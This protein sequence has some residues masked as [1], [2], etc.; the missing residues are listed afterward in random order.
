[1]NPTRCLIILLCS[2]LF[3]AAQISYGQI[4]SFS[5][6]ISGYTEVDLS[7]GPS[8]R[9]GQHVGFGTLSETLYY[10]SLAKTLRQVGSVTINPTVVSFPISD[11]GIY[12]ASGSANLTVNGGSSSL[13]FDTGVQPLLSSNSFFSISVAVNGTCD[14]VSSGQTNTAILNYSFVL[15]L[16]THIISATPTTLTLS[17]SASMNALNATTVGSA[18]GFSLIDGTVDD[19]YFFIWTLNPTVATAVPEPGTFAILSLVILGFALPH[20]R[21]H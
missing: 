14:V 20:R 2:A 9:G 15:P 16:E 4:Y 11:G 12:N 6:P 18:G 13:N 17:E 5:A 7:F 19:T 10:D 21:S 1:M 3:P 8:S